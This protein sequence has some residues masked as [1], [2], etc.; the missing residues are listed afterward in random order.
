MAPSFTPNP[1]EQCTDQLVTLPINITTQIIILDGPRPGAF[2]GII[3][4]EHLRLQANLPKTANSHVNAG[5]GVTAAH[6]T[7]ASERMQS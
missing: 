3:M 1:K 7:C 6:G 2:G 5:I 4:L